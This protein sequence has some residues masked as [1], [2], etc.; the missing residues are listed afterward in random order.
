M[1]IL[2]CYTFP[3]ITGQCAGDSVFEIE[4]LTQ[5]A[6]EKCRSDIS[7]HYKQLKVQDATVVF[8][9]VTKLDE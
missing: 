1:K 9:S 4:R 8:T 5:S 3:A 7:N 6:V 2:V